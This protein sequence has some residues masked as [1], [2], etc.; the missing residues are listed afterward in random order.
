[1]AVIHAREALLAAGWRSDVRL[2]IESGRIAAIAS[3]VGPLPGDERCAAVL[4]GLA[5]LHSH[6]FQRGMA[7]LAEV[8][9]S[10]AD[11]FWSWRDVMYRFALALTPEQVEAIAA[12][13][14][15]EM[16][17]AGFTHVAEFHYVHHDG[18]GQPYADP[19]ELSARV[20]AASSAT[21]I[22]MTVLPV[23]YAHGGFG[24]APTGPAQ[25]R[26]VSDLDQYARL[27]ERC[28]YH[29]AT[30]G[31]AIVGVAPHSLRAVTPGEL[32]EVDRLAAGTPIHIHIAEQTKEVDDC[33]AW[34]GA[35]PVQWLLDHAAVDARWCLIHATHMTDAE[36]LRLA[37]SGAVAGLCPV[38]EAN[39][40]DG[41][42]NAR[43]FV[44]AG[45]GFGVGSD[46]NVLIGVTDELRQ[47]EY[48]QRLRDRQRNIMADTVGSTGRALFDQ[49]VR[50]GA[51]AAGLADRGLCVGA[52]ASFVSLDTAQPAF[53]CRSGDAL[54][55]A[56]VF[57]SHGAID[58]VWVDGVR[59]VS[60]GRHDQRQAV[61]KRF[62][63]A[64]AG[65]LA[66]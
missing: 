5:N 17:E 63:S 32:A 51:Q 56:W 66:S 3:G 35:R 9:G 30:H 6:A 10:S 49:A 1:M 65:V 40:G 45:G 61:A 34:S 2:T 42:F 44:D 53:A 58:G 52:R 64:M 38:T 28:R 43:A 41:I 25:R 13:A 59:R 15:V 20:L 24:A 31:T 7:G 16:L 23:F 27:V 54:I 22:G 50:G 14:Y 21:G 18:D 19:A 39:L 36:T 33:L 26:F 29:A 60:G 62:G 47:L 37:R 4:P 55:D 57:A 12:Q 48:S 8:R 46:S 11:S